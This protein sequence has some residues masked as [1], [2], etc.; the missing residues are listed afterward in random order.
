[1]PDLRYSAALGTPDAWKSIVVDGTLV[2]NG[3]VAFRDIL[4][5]DEVETI[6]AYVIQRAHDEKARLAAE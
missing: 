3:M 1:V 5:Y 2:N 4:K 6:R